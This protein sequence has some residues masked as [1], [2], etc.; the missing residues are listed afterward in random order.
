MEDKPIKVKI[1]ADTNIYYN[2]GNGG[3]PFEAYQDQPLTPTFINIA[4]FSKTGHLVGQPELVREAL[5]KMFRYKGNVI[6]EPPFIYLA[7]VYCGYAFDAAKELGPILEM[8]SR[9]AKG[10][11]VDPEKLDEFDAWTSPIRAQ[12]EKATDFVN[13]TTAGMK[14]NIEDP[15]AHRKKDTI[16]LTM[17]VVNMFVEQNTS[18]AC[19]LWDIDLSR[20]ELLIKTMDVFSSAWKRPR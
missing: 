17:Q 2:L 1:I 12:F 9:L 4:E 18:G 13:Q 14:E 15:K 5:R 16:Q 20:S 6:Y 3:L 10:D 7:A 11:Q 8:T 19:V